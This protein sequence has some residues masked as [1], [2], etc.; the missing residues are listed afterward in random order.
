MRA[1]ALDH[2]SS[3]AGDDL[4]LA[5]YILQQ[6]HGVAAAN[7][8]LSL[9]KV[10]RPVYAGQ[11]EHLSALKT[12]RRR[13]VDYLESARQT[14]EALAL[15]RQLA[16][17]YP[18]DYWLQWEYG[19]SLVSDDQYEAAYAWID[20]VL[21]S[22]IRWLP[23][24]E[25]LLRDAVAGWLR[26]QGRYD[27]L[28]DYLAAWVRRSPPE[29]L[30]Y[31]QYSRRPGRGRS[32]GGGGCARRPLAPGRAAAGEAACRRGGAAGGGGR[33]GPAVGTV[34]AGAR[35]RGD[36]LRPSPLRSRSGQRHHERR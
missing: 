30:P 23:E 19:R 6:C 2:D 27:E 1:T 35:R 29:R 34:A 14:D 21:G 16:V 28:L 7:E 10:L 22:G 5:D 4:Y 3:P 12:W 18:R 9:L 13:Q 11:P 36:L 20:G 33:A 17:D 26:S 32:R 8:M 24:E 15:R 31:R 25:D